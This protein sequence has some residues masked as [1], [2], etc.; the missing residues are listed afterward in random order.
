MMSD[1]FFIPL[2]FVEAEMSTPPPTSLFRKRPAQQV[3]AGDLL[4]L[5]GQVWRVKDRHSGR[6][7]PRIT[8]T[9]WPVIGGRPETESFLPRAWIPTVRAPRTA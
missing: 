8:F 9:L 6:T 1:R 2:V 5:G 3:T 4:L 7:S